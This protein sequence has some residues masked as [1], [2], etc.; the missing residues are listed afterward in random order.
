MINEDVEMM[1]LTKAKQDQAKRDMVMSLMEKRANLE[2]LQEID[3][4]ENEM[5]W[6]YAEL[7]DKRESDIKEQ[8]AIAEAEREKIF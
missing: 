8:K 6:K 5:V 3:R 2:R 1:K 4:Y 7:Q